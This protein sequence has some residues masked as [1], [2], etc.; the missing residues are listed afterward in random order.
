MF[1]LHPTTTAQEADRLTIGDPVKFLSMDGLE[2][3]DTIADKWETSKGVTLEFTNTEETATF[4]PAPE[5]AFHRLHRLRMENDE[6]AQRMDALRPRFDA[7]RTRHEDG[8]APR[9]VSAFNLFQT[10]PALAARM[11]ALV[12]EGAKSI[13]EPSA[14]LGRLYTAA[15]ALH[16]KTRI[17]LVEIAPECAG[18]L[19]SITENDNFCTLTQKDF[20]EMPEMPCSFYD[21]IIMNPPFKMRRDIKHIMHALNYLKSGGTLIG[22][23]LAGAIREKH[24][25]PLCTSW[26]SIPAG[27]FKTEGTRVETILFTI[28]K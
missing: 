20:L 23:C 4:L 24:L 14:G 21:A 2:T 5:N 19:Y 16:P 13:L 7:L 27:T 9:A 15:R 10:P 11:A 22:L 8:T 6:H 3:L 25:M 1:T 26:E 17:D 18:E 28:T 12:P